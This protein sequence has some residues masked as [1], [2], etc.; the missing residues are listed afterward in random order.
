MAAPDPL[1]L[2]GGRV[3]FVKD[4]KLPCRLTEPEEVGK[5]GLVETRPTRA[6]PHDESIAAPL[7][8]QPAS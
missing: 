6:V 8:A 4:H 7:P 3:N 1:A 5:G 2:G